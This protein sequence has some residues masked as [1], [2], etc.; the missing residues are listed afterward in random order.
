MHDL[1]IQ[2]LLVPLLQRWPRAETALLFLSLPLMVLEGFVLRFR[3][4]RRR[5]RPRS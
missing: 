1:W 5:P 4:S 2:H 3:P